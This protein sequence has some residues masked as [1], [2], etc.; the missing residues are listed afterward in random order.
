MLPVFSSRTSHGALPDG[1][2]RSR[3]AK[4]IRLSTQ[5]DARAKPLETKSHLYHQITSSDITTRAYYVFPRLPVS[6]RLAGGTTDTA[7]PVLLLFP[8]AEAVRVGGVTS[9]PLIS[10]ARA[11]ASSCG[12]ARELG[13]TSLPPE[14]TGGGVAEASVDIR[15][16]SKK[17]FSSRERF[18]TSLSLGR[19]TCTTSGPFPFD[20]THSPVHSCPPVNR[21]PFT[22]TLTWYLNLG[23]KSS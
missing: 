3:S 11:A 10:I 15:V 7:G 16:G 19:G 12:S 23:M 9:N 4:T 1:P 21:P 2:Q 5:R 20:S 18:L 22:T 17:S 6:A 14:V 13:G 8:S